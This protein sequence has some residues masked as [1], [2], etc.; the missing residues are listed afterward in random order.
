MSTTLS[1]GDVLVGLMSGTSLDG[2][3]AC[4][5]RF[6]E[7]AATGSVTPELLAQLTRPYSAVQRARLAAAMQNA[8]P[9]EYTRLD[10]ELGGWLADAAVAAIAECGVPREQIRAVASHGQTLWH[11]GRGGSWQSGS[12]AMIAER[13][14]IDVI[15][16]FRSRD[17][18]AGGEGAPLVPIADA[19]LFA[20]ADAWRVLQNLGG[21]GNLTLLPPLAPM[22]ADLSAVRGFDTGPG[23]RVIDGVTRLLRPELEFDRDGAIAKTGSPIEAVLEELLVDPW[24]ATAPPKST[25][26]ERYTD[27]FIAEFVASCRRARPDASDGDIVA[28][29]VWFTARSLGLAFDHFIPQPVE[30]VLLSGGGARNPVLREAIA[31][32]L[33][34]R[35]V[36]PF[37][38]LYFDG[39][40]K[41]AVAFAFL[42]W[43]HLRRR[44]GNLPSA[45][46]ARGPRVLGALYPK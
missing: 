28:T 7:D 16:D 31:M 37:E 5:V 42:G 4:V 46:G 34:P 23:V 32:T 45:T 21:M 33:A 1:R 27:A 9:D 40:A 22:A 30:D 13:T 11:S 35:I 20:R 36:R 2:V 10:L 6:H 17:I 3:T 44:A 19:M 18:A 29:A 25:G 26:R 24:F 8:T 14:G 38:E 41:E 15:A 12:A 43:L 39:D